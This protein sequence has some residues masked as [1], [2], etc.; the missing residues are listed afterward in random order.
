MFLKFKIWKARARSYLGILA[1]SFSLNTTWRIPRDAFHYGG[2]TFA[3]LVTIALVMVA[4]PVVLLQLSMGQLSQQDPVGVWT[5]VPLFKGVGYLRLLITYTASI[6]VII[7][8][9]MSATI[10][11]YTINN[12]IPFGVCTDLLDIAGQEPEVVNYNATLCFNETF[13]SP[14]HEKP[15]YYIALSLLIVFIW[16]L[17]PFILYRPVKSLRVIFYVLGPTAPILWII[18]LSAAGD[19]TSLSWFSKRDDWVNLLRP[20]IWNKA[21]AQAL[22]TAHVAGGFLISSGDSIF[23]TS[24]V[25]WTSL[26]LV[27]SNIITAWFGL[28]IWFALGDSEAGN[29]VFAVL[30]RTYNSTIEKNL[31]TVW[32]IL[33][34]ATLF[35]SGLISIVSLLYPLYDRF[36]RIQGV[37][38][39]YISIGSSL[40]GSGLA[41]ALLLDHNAL[42][43]LEDTVLPFL[44]NFTTIIEISA[45]VFVYGW[46]LLLHDI[47][48][49]TG[50]ELLRFWVWGLCSVPG[51]IAPILIWWYT[52]HYLTAPQWT[53]AP[54]AATGLTAA[55]AITIIIIISFAIYSVARQVQYDTI[56]KMKSSI[57]PSRH[58]GPR[59]PIAHYYWLMR[60]DE[61][62]PHAPRS[63]Y[64]RRNL[65]QFSGTSSVLS[66][67]KSQEISDVPKEVKR[68]SNSDDWLYSYRKEYLAELFEMHYPTRRRSKSLDWP[69]PIDKVKTNS[70]TSTDDSVIIVE[71][72][73][74]SKC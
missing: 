52:T 18:I 59:D 10:F 6:C 32:P 3:L 8:L 57:R 69:K 13:F 34:F 1:L 7:Y 61:A 65:G 33:I 41:I 64:H 21:I 49:L 39:R 38:W 66:I 47:E 40:V 71:N 9:A 31:S 15:E 16:L 24:D 19:K 30:I 2:L 23:V 28:I 73:V 42:I 55:T 17:F 56:S 51:I 67:P 58:W 45:F 44:V 46:N 20:H 43:V 27:G 68:R 48:F 70:R 60:R 29:D 74:T 72:N 14:I 36:R 22:I 11:L 4:L 35:L 26:S 53:Q 54:W 12:S 63:R 37:K 62:D 25:E 5:A 50:R